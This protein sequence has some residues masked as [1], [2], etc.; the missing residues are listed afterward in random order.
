MRRLCAFLAV[1]IAFLGLGAP[2]FAAS[3]PPLRGELVDIGGRHIRVLCQGPR[4][5]KPLVIFETGI[6]GGAAA[7][8]EVQ[9]RLV[10][11]GVRSCAYDR[12]GLGFSDPGPLPRDANNLVSDLEAWLKAKGEAGPYV[13]VAHSMGGLETRM[14]A[15]RHPA[16]IAGVVLVDTTS[17]DLAGTPDG[18]VFLKSY[19]IFS[20]LAEGLSRLGVLHVIAPVLGD[21]EGLTGDAHR[22]MIYFFGSRQHQRYAIAEISQAYVRGKEAL[23]A[24]QMDPGIP[25]TA[26]I[27][28]GEDGESM[29]WGPARTGEA[30]ASRH[31]SVVALTHTAHPELI[32]PKHADT[33]VTAINGVMAAD[34]TRAMPAR[35]A[36]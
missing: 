33:V 19:I 28:D 11:Q 1:L 35:P 31:G 15:A 18:R 36:P 13:L 8:D 2:A 25:V 30:R 5:D 27:F 14:F 10:A 24:G 29:A 4:S 17:P 22:E 7:W 6:F 9:T 3:P 12:A 20:R 23:A 32:G 21:Q 16:Q 26:I 34:A